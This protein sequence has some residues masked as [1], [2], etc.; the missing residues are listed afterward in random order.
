M[1]LNLFLRNIDLPRKTNRFRVMQFS[2]LLGIITAPNT[3]LRIRAKE[4]R[5]CR[6]SYV[7]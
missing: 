4:S 7:D 6:L 5:K 2:P 3:H 1:E